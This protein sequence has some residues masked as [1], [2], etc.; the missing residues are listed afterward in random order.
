M[1]VV[2]VPEFGVVVGEQAVFFCPCCG[3]RTLEL[4]PPDSCDICSICGWEDDID[5]RIQS[6][7]HQSGANSMSIAEAYGNYI[8]FG[9]IYGAE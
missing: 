7:H 2:T 3:L 9:T 4:R 5:L 1:V 8:R 6:C